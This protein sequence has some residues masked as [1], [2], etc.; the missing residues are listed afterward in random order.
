MSKRAKA[1]QSDMKRFLLV[2]SEDVSGTSGTGVVAEGVQFSNGRVSLHW[3]S[4]YE[5]VEDVANIAVVEQIH[6]HEGKTRIEW[7]DK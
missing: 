4:Q 6:G 3:I 2:R 7:V 1:L 5:S